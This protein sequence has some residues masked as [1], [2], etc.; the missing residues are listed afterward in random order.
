MS[1]RRSSVASPLSVDDTIA[2][3]QSAIYTITE[4]KKL[5][6]N[7]ADEYF[8]DD[9]VESSSEEGDSAKEREEKSKKEAAEKRKKEQER[10]QKEEKERKEQEQKKKKK[11]NAS[12]KGWFSW[13]SRKDDGPKPIKAKMGEENQFYYDEKLKR[14]I[15]KNAPV[16]EQIADTAP[17][18][19]P[20]KKEP[21]SQRIKQTSQPLPGPP[22]M[23]SPP[24]PNSSSI[25]KPSLSGRPQK[26]EN[27]IDGLLSL[28]AGLQRSKKRS[29]RG[30]RRGYVDVMALQGKK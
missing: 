17:P 10:K 21:D 28:S 19:P 15:N 2:S 6:A 13:L 1:S 27:G 9:I 23:N 3:K 11:S 29:R 16:E 7:D 5:Y 30:P 4:E 24:A 20:M 25:S 14:W 22:R 8:D 26:D 12:S 18:P